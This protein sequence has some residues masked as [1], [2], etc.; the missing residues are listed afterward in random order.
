MIQATNIVNTMRPSV[1]T[2]KQHKHCKQKSTRTTSIFPC[3]NVGAKRSNDGK[4]NNEGGTHT[5][6]GLDGF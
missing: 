4:N 1:S 6:R 5:E 2:D 3:N